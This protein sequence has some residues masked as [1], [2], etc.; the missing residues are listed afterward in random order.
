MAKWIEILVEGSVSQFLDLNESRFIYNHYAN[1]QNG[2]GIAIWFWELP[3]QTQLEIFHYL[4]RLITKLEKHN[5]PVWVDY[6][7]WETDDINFNDT[8]ANQPFCSL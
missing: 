5:L 1:L 6:Q 2:E 3:R 4:F 8:K 7:T